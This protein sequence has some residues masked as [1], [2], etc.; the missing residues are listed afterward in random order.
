MIKSGAHKNVLIIGAEVFS[1]I[2]NFEDRTT[3]VLFGDGAGAVVMSAR[4][5]PGCWRPNCMPMADTRY[6]ICARAGGQGG[7][8]GSAYADGW[9][10]SL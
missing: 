8:C 5:S 9:S 10:G 2:L 6:F 4:M 1:R 7:D 3:C